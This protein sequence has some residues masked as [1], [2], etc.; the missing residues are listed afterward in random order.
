[1]EE[2]A[3]NS[4]TSGSQVRTGEITAQRFCNTNQGGNMICK[5]NQTQKPCE[6][7]KCVFQDQRPS[8][9]NRKNRKKFRRR[10]RNQRRQKASSK[11]K[12][13]A[14][15]QKMESLGNSSV[16][17]GPPHTDLHE[18]DQQHTVEQTIPNMVHAQTQTGHPGG[19]NVS[20]Q[21]PVVHHSNQNTQTEEEEEP[22][23]S[24]SS[25]EESQPKAE[26]QKNPDQDS[27]QPPGRRTHS[28]GEAPNPAENLSEGT[29]CDLAHVHSQKT[30]AK[31]VA[32]QSGPKSQAD[33]RT[34]EARDKLPEPPQNLQ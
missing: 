22:S 23:V 26:Q 32:G 3:G 11:V 6:V 24:P 9:V 2:G 15:G 17:T 16:P 25:A 5:L 7:C 31:A 21:T 14:K 10:Q 1:M 13:E 8:S 30:Y 28:D 12:G 4:H 33:T 18:E 19:R 34:S 20:T 27:A 29:P